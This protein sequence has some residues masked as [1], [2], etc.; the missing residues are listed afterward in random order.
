MAEIKGFFR[1][2]PHPHD[3]GEKVKKSHNRG[4]IVYRCPRS[5]RTDPISEEFVCELQDLMELLRPGL[6]DELNG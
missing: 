2:C 5:S 3:V 4:Y 1:F 6:R